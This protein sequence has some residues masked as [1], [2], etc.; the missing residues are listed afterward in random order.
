MET[1]K[2]V[3]DA[4]CARVLAIL[5]GDQGAMI[6]RRRDQT[7]SYMRTE[8]AHPRPTHLVNDGK[9]EDLEGLKEL[10]GARSHPI[11]SIY[12]EVNFR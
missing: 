2:D 10:R 12:R 6:R 5:R 9:G 1:A 7:L 3:I 11:W 4:N 8:R